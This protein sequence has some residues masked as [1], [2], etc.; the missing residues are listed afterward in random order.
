MKSAMQHFL[1]LH[2][3][4]VEIPQTFV[5][6]RNSSRGSFSLGFH[7]HA[8]IQVS[9][10]IKLSSASGKTKPHFFLYFFNYYF[11]YAFWKFSIFSI[12]VSYCGMYVSQVKT[13]I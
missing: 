10:I 13:R 1:Q 5:F 8:V 4:K 12:F 2:N 7:R 11:L 3:S 6:L 9:P